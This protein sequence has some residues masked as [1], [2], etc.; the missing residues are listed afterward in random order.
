MVRFCSEIIKHVLTKTRCAVYKFALNGSSRRLND[1]SMSEWLQQDFMN[2]HKNFGNA[3]HLL[4]G[5]SF[6]YQLA[7]RVICYIRL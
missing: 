4:N 1:L 3:T 7:C 6:K 2:Y 5:K